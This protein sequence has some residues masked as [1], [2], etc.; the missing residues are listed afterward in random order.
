MFAHDTSIS[1]GGGLRWNCWPPFAG[2]RQQRWSTTIYP[3]PCDADSR[4]KPHGDQAFGLATLGSWRQT[5]THKYFAVLFFMSRL[6]AE[7]Q[8]LTGQRGVSGD[9]GSADLLGDVWWYIGGKEYDRM[10]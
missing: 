9:S 7:V 3:S 6:G 5:N 8:R 1:D 2:K 10:R 4:N